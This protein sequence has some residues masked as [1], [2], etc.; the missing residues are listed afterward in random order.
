MI[1]ALSSKRALG[2]SSA[3]LPPNFS[4]ALISTSVPLG[5]HGL[6]LSATGGIGVMLALPPPDPQAVIRREVA[7]NAASVARLLVCMRRR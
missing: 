3:S 5:M 7:K 6:L 2:Q 4:A 1:G